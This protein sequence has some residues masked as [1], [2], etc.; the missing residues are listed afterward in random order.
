[1]QENCCRLAHNKTPLLTNV[2]SYGGM[3]LATPHSLPRRQQH[4]RA[5]LGNAAYAICQISSHARHRQKICPALLT[6]NSARMQTEVDSFDSG[7]SFLTLFLTQ[8]AIHARDRL[9][10]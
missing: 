6:Y 5:H 8:S 10:R 7:P 2:V 9:H 3:L 4:E 1:M